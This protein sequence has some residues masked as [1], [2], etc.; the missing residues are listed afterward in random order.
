MRW[1]AS[2]SA[3]LALCGFPYRAD[4]TAPEADS[5]PA[6]TIGTVAWARVAAFIEGKADPGNG[7]LEGDIARDVDEYYVAGVRWA[8]DRKRIGWR[9][10][11]MF[12]W[13]P[14]KDEAREL[15]A[16]KVLRDYEHTADCAADCVLHCNGDE[17]PGS[18]DLVYFD[19]DG[20]LNVDDVK[21]GVTPLANYIP[22]IR[23]LGMMAARAHHVR[24]VRVRLI[25][26]YKDKLHD[27][28]F[29]ELD[30]FALDAIAEE[31][32]AELKAA[33]TAE[34]NPGSHCTELWCPARLVC[35]EVG[36]AIAE[37]V[38]A[39]A[40][41]KR[42]K[43]SHEFVS[44]DN[45]AALLDFVRL[46]DK[47]TEDLRKVIKKRTPPGGVI[48]AD[49]R[50]LREGFHDESRFRQ[51]SLIGK[52]RELGAKAGLADE[53]IE[54]AL[55]DCKYSFSK[56]EGLKVVKITKAKAA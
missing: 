55:E 41:V 11:V 56:S 44:H 5:G 51:E 16:S 26:L 10:E 13:S 24:R 3:L 43:W 49:G 47:A 2:K 38:P 15:P 37:L 35:P 45:D 25:K 39:E 34:P 14:S 31:R 30:G 27:E 1:S 7:V 17:K 4:V 40:L 54:K 32:C 12:A 20:I 9:C 33:E 42:P 6:A 22:Q 52:L 28:W 21:T 8:T 46:V 23:T 36:V 29:D 53:D 48:L 50:L 18:T 19:S